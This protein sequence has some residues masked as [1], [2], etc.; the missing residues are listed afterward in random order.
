MGIDVE[1]YFKATE[2]LTE[3]EMRELSLEDEKCIE[4][5]FPNGATHNIS[6]LHRYYGPGYQRGNWP[7]ICGCLMRLFA[8][9]KIEA[10]WYFGDSY[11]WHDENEAPLK[12]DDVLEI[13]RMYMTDGDRPYRDA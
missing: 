9:E 11:N 3:K 10:I 4:G 1:I 8:C 6:S 12:I 5:E 13:S 2:P 7:L